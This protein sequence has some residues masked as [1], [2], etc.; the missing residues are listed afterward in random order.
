MVLTVVMGL[1]AHGTR[2]DAAPPNVLFIYADDQSYKTIGCYEESPDWVQTPNIDQLAASGIRFQRAYLGAW[3]MPSRASMLTGRLQH[4]VQSMRMSGTYPGSSYDPKACPFVPA[5]L[6]KHGY[7]TAQIGKWHTGTDTG[8]GRDWDFQVVWNRPAQPDNAGNYYYDQVLTINGRDVREPEYSTDHY[9]KW[10][11]EY[12]AGK[13]RQAGKPWFLWLCYGAIHGP[14]TP[15]DRHQG[16]LDGHAPPIPKDLLGPWPDK[17]AYL[18]DT[19]AWTLDQQGRPAMKRKNRDAAN[20]DTSDAG[21]TLEDWVQQV[22]ECN[23]AVD[24]GVGQ[25]I[26]ALRDSGQL[27]N[28]LIIYTA[29]QG[30][31]LGEHGLNQKIAPYDAAIASAL[32]I[33]QAGSIQAG[34]VCPHPVNSPDLVDLICRKTGVDLPWRTDGRNI[35]P[36]LDDPDS[37]HWH[38]PMLMTHTARMY[39][40]DTDVIPSD[41]RLTAAGGVPWYVL[42]RLGPYKYIR[43]MVPGEMEEVYHLERDPDELTNLALRSESHELLERLRKTAQSELARTEAGFVDRLPP[44]MQMLRG[45]E[46]LRGA[47][48]SADHETR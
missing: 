7:H 44:T 31:A 4:G 40:S 42:L 34:K 2:V 28:T 16:K 39:G 38:A 32:I 9:T 36:L 25:V 46:D 17:P 18:N 8:F 48:D 24:E 6:R 35:Q 3:C 5:E 19:S 23:L 21:K 20:F 47:D 30:Y 33:S 27:E 1:S 26:Q 15:A 41:D 37:E 43:T 22:N 13:H 14:T 11:T 12:I 29:D 10:A 45:A